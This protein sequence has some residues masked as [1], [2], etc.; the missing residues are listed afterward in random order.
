M[1]NEQMEAIHGAICHAFACLTDAEVIEM[2]ME[3]V[4]EMRLQTFVNAA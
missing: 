1:T 3:P 2:A 4:S